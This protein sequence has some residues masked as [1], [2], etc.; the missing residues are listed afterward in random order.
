M[1][2]PTR[3]PRRTVAAALTAIVLVVACGGSAP[4][5]QPAATASGAPNAAPRPI[6]IDADM[7]HSDLAAIAILLRDPAVDVRAITI[8]GTGLV[9]CA[10][11]R[12]VTRYL[13][14]QMGTTDIP[15]ACGRE[16][17]GPDARPFPDEWRA[18]AD[19]AYGLVIPPQ[20]QAGLP[21]DAT[22]LFLEAVATSPTAPTVVALGPWTNLE[23]AFAADPTVAGRIAGIHSM[24]GVVDAS[25]NVFVDGLGGD[26]PL[27]W[28]AFADPSSVNAVFAADVPIDLVPLDAT[29]DVPV[30]ADLPDRLS[31]DPTAAGADLMIELLTR[32]P[33]RLR[34]DEGQQLWDELAALAL[35]APDLVTWQD[36]TLTV[37]EGGR[38]TRDDA[39]RDTRIAVAAD[40][41]AV[42]AALLSALQR[43]PAR[44]TP[45]R[46]A[47]E[48]DATFDGTACRATMSAASTPPVDGLYRLRYTGPSAAPSGVTMV[49]VV[50]PKRW[51]DLVAWIAKVDL[52]TQPEPPAWVVM[53]PSVGDEA[54]A[55]TPVSVAG[56]LPAGTVG[57]V[58]LSGTWPDL[59]FVPGTSFEVA[60]RP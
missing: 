56:A 9:H 10:G 21:P 42:E 14:E 17:G 36:A 27:E 18:V 34:T 23:D 13:L 47:G 38:L 51:S 44:M 59:T 31:A 37:G 60:D 6:V 48:I 32:N 49:G 16:D 8:S 50:A 46:L 11:G 57:P 55:G 20:P 39:G 40:R 28:N 1:T 15:F 3:V 33:S 22:S 26:D 5:A 19:D 29:D 54:G 24:L 4:T 43:G 12:R 45:F 7:D 52:A 41:P 53:G 25:G 35:T 2:A 58:C 30:P